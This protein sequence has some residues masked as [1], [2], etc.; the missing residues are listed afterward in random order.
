MKKALIY[1]FTVP[2]AILKGNQ[3]F[4]LHQREDG[5][6]LVVIETCE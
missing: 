6:D 2:C 1:H 3:A 5:D 4:Q